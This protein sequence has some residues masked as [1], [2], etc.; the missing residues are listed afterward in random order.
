MVF[1]L[2]GIARRVVRMGGMRM[3]GVCCQRW[4]VLLAP[5]GSLVGVGILRRPLLDKGHFLGARWHWGILLGTAVVH[6]C[7][8]LDSLDNPAGRWVGIPGQEVRP[9]LAGSWVGSSCPA[10]S[11]G[12]RMSCTARQSGVMWLL[13]AGQATRYQ[14]RSTAAIFTSGIQTS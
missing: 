6:R 12:I 9:G 2:P 14:G 10:P 8:L 3:A 13:S 7:C 5:Q 11:L 1:N 4:E